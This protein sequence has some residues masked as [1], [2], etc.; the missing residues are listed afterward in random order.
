MTMI[1]SICRL[2]QRFVKL[3]NTDVLENSQYDHAPQPS[4][5]SSW[6]K[7]WLDKSPENWPRKCSHRDCRR[8]ADR[9]GHVI[10][11]H[12]EDFEFIIPTCQYHK[13]PTFSEIFS[14]KPETLAVNIGKKEIKTELAE[15]LDDQ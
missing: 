7:Y 14:V 5:Y 11:N 1:S 8:D 9:S 13:R 2:N 10:V 4:G 3:E 12:D 6:R 15:N